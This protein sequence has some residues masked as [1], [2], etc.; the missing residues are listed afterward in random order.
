MKR[1]SRHFTFHFSLYTFI[2]VML[3]LMIAS[4]ARMG[5]PDGGWYDEEPP[6]VVATSPMENA[7]NFNGNRV[8]LLFNEYIKLENA[9]EKVVVSPPQLEQPEIKLQGNRIRIDLKDSL[10]ANQT[11]TIDFSDCISDNNENNP[12]GNYTFTF[13]TGDHIDTMEV[14]GNV[15]DAE[16]LEPIKG[17]LVGLYEND[18][19]TQEKGDT[20]FRTQTMIR[21][22]RSDGE[23]RFCIKGVAKDKQYRV[24]ALEDMDGDLKY[25]QASEGMAFS[26]QIISPDCYPDNRLDTIW[27]DELRI[28]DLVRVPFTHFTPD[29]I[30]L[31]M[32]KVKQQERHL[33]KKDRNEPE[34]L[35]LFFTYGDKS[36][37]TFR[38]L[39]FEAKEN[40]NYLVEHSVENDS[41]IYWLS[42]SL[43]INNDSLI[44][45]LSY[46]DTDTLGELQQKLDTLEFV[47]KLSL[48][49][50]QK[51]K[52]EEYK[53]WKK[54][55]DKKQ[56]KNEPF[57]TEFPK[58]PLNI[59][60]N[61]HS[62]MTPE[63]RIS[64]VVPSPVAVIDSS[65]IHLKMKV[66]TLYEDKPFRLEEDSLYARTYYLITDF[67]E[68]EEYKL[69]VDSFAI[70]DIYDRLSPAYKANI[71]IGEEDSYGKLIVDVTGISGNQYVFQLYS[72]AEKIAKQVITTKPSAEFRYLKSGDYYLKL[73]VDDDCDGKFTTGLYD[74]GIQPEAVYY[75]EEKLPIKEKWDKTISWNPLR[76]PLNRQKPAAIIKQKAD[77]KKVL[78]TDRNMKRARDM[79][80][81]FLPDGTPVTGSNDNNNQRR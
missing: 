18:L 42:D 34:Q 31:R 16:T 12:M 4:C 9:Q 5:N 57:E 32:S 64:F 77:R 43:L 10:I 70:R 2:I 65:M 27:A 72:G 1:G 14:S 15:I 8:Y 37:P 22:A 61:A 19:F 3:T 29:D 46:L 73:I 35:K 7:V 75:Y 53:K 28:K 23:G 47:P 21:V 67:K 36:L 59:K 17:A 45:E 39:N 6:Y 26:N 80:L 78:Q 51:L 79:G 11:Y 58:Q 74:E 66:D 81:K 48:E 25:S 41:I 68:K 49:R 60:W 20:I 24:F 62:T 44:V 40:V 38:P 55:Q 56:K 50:R 30:V 69:E 63:D 52:D 76:V 71:K 13:S 33:L 54:E